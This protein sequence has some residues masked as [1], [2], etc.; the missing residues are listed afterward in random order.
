M[1]NHE[2]VMYLSIHIMSYCCTPG[3]TVTMTSEDSNS[4]TAP[5]TPA[6]SQTTGSPPACVTNCSTDQTPGMCYACVI[7]ASPVSQGTTF[8]RISSNDLDPNTLHAVREFCIQISRHFVIWNP[9][10]V[11]ENVLTRGNN[12]GRACC[13][14]DINM[15]LVECRTLG[16]EPE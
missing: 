5:A 7:S 1:Y 6:G 10:Y 16:G 13:C 4:S 12:T 3:A 2:L 11:T 8:R 9:I 14:I 15:I